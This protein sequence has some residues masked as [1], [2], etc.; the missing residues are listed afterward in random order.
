MRNFARVTLRGAKLP[1]RIFHLF[2]V[3]VSPAQGDICFHVV[4]L[5]V[6]LF[7]RRIISRRIIC[8]S[9]LQG[10]PDRVPRLPG[11]TVMY[12]AVMYFPARAALSRGARWYLA[13]LGLCPPPPPGSGAAMDVSVRA[14]PPG[15]A[16]PGA[17]F[18]SVLVSGFLCLFLPPPGSCL[19]VL[20][21]PAAASRRS[22]RYFV[23]S[24]LGS[25]FPAG[26]S[27]PTPVF[28]LGSASRH[29][30]GSSGVVIS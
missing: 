11:V 28:P 19:C 4:L 14:H 3:T 2:L 23:Y 5:S 6:V 10:S 12:S 26:S 7:A 22:L 25:P 27:F 17:R 18:V 9:Y 1:P 8:T 20:C 16:F 21:R 24:P 15:G 29:R 30:P 13:H